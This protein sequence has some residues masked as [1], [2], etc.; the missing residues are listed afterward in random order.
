MVMWE[1]LKD[2]DLED[3]KEKNQVKHEGVL[4]ECQELPCWKESD[5]NNAAYLKVVSTYL[6]SLWHGHYNF[7]RARRYTLTIFLMKK[8]KH[9]CLQH[10]YGVKLRLTPW[11]SYS[12]LIFTSLH[13]QTDQTSWGWCLNCRNCPKRHFLNQQREGPCENQ[14][15]AA[16]RSRGFLCI[17]GGLWSGA[18]GT[19]IKKGFVK[20]VE[21][22]TK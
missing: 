12:E 13:W 2:P 11:F 10:F 15:W 8:V 3:R 17:P 6:I 1:Q 7:L 18:R 22:W 5:N 19:A 20:R 4:Q 21:G 16:S 14:N 9:Q